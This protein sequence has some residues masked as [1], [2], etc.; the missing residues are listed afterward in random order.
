MDTLA[1]ITRLIAFDTT[2]RHS[3][4]PL[5]TEINDWFSYHHITPRL[6]YDATKQKANLFATLP[7]RDGRIDGGLVLSGHTDVVPVDE[8]SWQTNPFEAVQL[9]NKVYGRGACDMKGFI[10]VLLALLPEFQKL[11][12]SYPIHFAFSYDEEIGC[13]GAPLLIADLQQAGIKPKACIVGEPTDMHMVVA[14]KGIQ[15]FRCRVHGLA[16]HSSLTPA[17]CNAIDYAAKL[18]SFIRTY[19]NE[20]RQTGPFDTHFDVPFTSIS[21][22]MIHGGTARNII[23]AECEFYFE[24]RYLPQMKPETIIEKIRSYA[25]NEL[26]PEMQR[27]Y[28]NA[29]IAIDN[30]GAAPSFEASSEAVIKH[31]AAD[32]LAETDIRKVAYATEA[33]LFQQANIPTIICGPGH[34]EQA[35][36]PDEFVTFVQLEKCETF[37]RALVKRLS[38]YGRFLTHS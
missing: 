25:Q 10:A 37:L 35:H 34:I 20:L 11:S 19:A 21:T 6:T 26:L 32:L 24:F 1:W 30:Q 28:A 17:A 33:G 38:C 2:S 7:A 9:N 23:P 8:Q 5:I 18:I 27:E 14:H 12:L 31:L 29:S 4:L 15:V 16:A 13:I 3:N 22:N 36:R